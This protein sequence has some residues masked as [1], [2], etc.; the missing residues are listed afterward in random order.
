M[1]KSEQQIPEDEGQRFADSIDAIFQS[2]SE[3]KI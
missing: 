2:A 3:L 1:I